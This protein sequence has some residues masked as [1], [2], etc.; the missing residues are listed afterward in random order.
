MSDNRFANRNSATKRHRPKR[1]G[2]VNR[3]AYLPEPETKLT[4]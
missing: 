1:I 4:I 3:G 2:Y